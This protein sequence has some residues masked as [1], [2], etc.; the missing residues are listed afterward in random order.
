VE[1]TMT[2]HDD[3]GDDRNRRDDEARDERAI[4]RILRDAGPR[5]RP[6]TADANDVRA[7]VEAEWRAIVDRRRAR[8]RRWALPLAA[9]VA[10]A[11]VGVAVLVN[12]PAAPL[13][14]VATVERLD[15]AVEQR[16]A[17]S[18]SW[19]RL[20]P[21]ASVRERDEIRT[22]AGARVALRLASGLELRLDR[23]SQ[24]AFGDHAHATLA[25]GAV[26]VDS[27]SRPP[28]QAAAFEVVTSHG[29]VRHLGTQYE[30][31]LGDGVLVVS[32]REGR[33]SV[34]RSADRLE[35][36]A[37]ERLVIGNDRVVR[38][39]V[40]R[41]DPGWGW[42]GEIAPPYRLEGRTLQQFLDWAARETGREV[43]F[44]DSAA[45]DEAVALELHGSIEGLTP[46]EALTAVLATTSM[47]VAVG[48]DRID[49]GARVR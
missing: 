28:A 44:A 27:G 6:T 38:S 42:T 3:S 21:G 2:T 46:D 15:G 35:G 24:L 49:V 23:G 12:R 17:D 43:R 19:H 4:E 47:P 37:G 25:A 48:S 11:A 33:V 13:E 8:T 41:S 36:A 26:Y 39:S 18:R 7:A 5:E 1:I 40:A 10:A 20:A 22:S 29:S 31:R 34:A 16:P 45:R 32:V 9:G 30:A 14:T